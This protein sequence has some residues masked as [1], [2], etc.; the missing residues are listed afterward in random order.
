MLHAKK[1][2]IVLSLMSRGDSHVT[3]ALVGG[4]ETLFMWYAE[5]KHLVAH[6]QN[7]L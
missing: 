2:G 3:C 6:F 4:G 7:T 5:M 1:A